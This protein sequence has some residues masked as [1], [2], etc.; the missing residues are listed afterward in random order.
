MNAQEARLI[1][2]TAYKQRNSNWDD[3]F[4]NI[5]AIVTDSNGNFYAVGDG[6]GYV[7]HRTVGSGDVIVAKFLP[8]KSV[9]LSWGNNASLFYANAPGTSFF[10]HGFSSDNSGSF[11]HRTNTVDYAGDSEYVLGAVLGADSN[12]YILERWSKNQNKLAILSVGL[13]GSE[14]G[15]FGSNGWLE[16][17]EY[18]ETYATGSIS[19]AD[20]GS[21]KVTAFGNVYEYPIPRDSVI[22]SAVYLLAPTLSTVNEGSTASF[23]LS[24]S[25]VAAGTALSYVISGVQA[26]DIVGG[27]LTGSVNVGSNGQATISVP[28]AADNLT[29]GTETMT[30]TVRSPQGA[31][32]AST[33]V[34]INDTSRSPVIN[35]SYSLTASAS[36][37]NEGSTASFTLNTSNVAVGTAL[38]YVISGVQ[39]ADIV[40][41]Q[42]TGSVNVGSNGQATISI[43]IAA[44][45]LTEGPETMTVTVRSPQGVNVASANVTIN[46]TSVRPNQSSSGLSSQAMLS[47]QNISFQP[48]QPTVAGI[49]WNFSAADF[50]FRDFG[51]QSITYRF[52]A[53]KDSTYDIYALSINDPLF[54]GIYDERGVLLATNNELFDPLVTRLQ[55]GGEYDSDAIYRWSPDSTGTFY[56][57]VTYSQTAAFPF[58]SF[59]IYEE[60]AVGAVT[61]NPNYLLQSVTSSV[62]EGASAS[63]SL[64]T[65]NL[66]AGT[67]LSYLISGVQA[68][69]IVGGQLSG[70]VTVDA[71]GRATI[72]IPIAA[73]NLTE[74]P[75]T[76]TVTVRSPQGAN[77]ASA[78][79][80]INDT[81]TTRAPETMLRAPAGQSKIA[82]SQP[83]S[84]AVIS[85]DSSG[86][87]TVTLPGGSSNRLEGYKR[88]EFADKTVALDTEAVGGQAYR[89]YKAAFN[90]EPDQGGLGYWIAQ[91]DSGMNMVEVAARFIDSNEF[92]SL[93]GNNP[94]DAVFLTR[95]YQNVLGREPEP[96]GYN[97]WLNELRTNPE[98][99]RA[100]VLADFSES[101]ENKVGVS[102]LISAGVVFQPYTSKEYRVVSR[103]AEVNEGQTA[104]FDVS[105]V[106]VAAGTQLAYTITGVSAADIVGGQLS[107]T[108]NV[109]SN[110]KATISIPIAADNLTEGRETLQV[111]LQ[112]QNA[113]VVINDTS[114]SPVANPTYSLTASTVSVNEGASAVFTLLTTQV[115]AGT[116]FS[117]LL[118]GIQAADIVGGQLSGTVTV[119]AW[120][121]AT[122]SIPIVA[123]NL[124]EGPEVLTVAIR[125][126]QGSTLASSS[127]VIND[128][129]VTIVGISDGGDSGGGG[130]GGGGG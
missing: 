54:L 17:G 56:A 59:E 7:G 49:T 44:D 46:D 10:N 32:V 78:N 117:Y 15:Y 48:Y 75:E 41:G 100:K 13:D 98:K 70:S 125:S 82:F 83:V 22:A 81:S 111:N 89:V 104:V 8:N 40:G 42:L 110:G 61:S 11:N 123:D 119:N 108:I 31:N 51:G 87:W 57:L 45:N 101:A 38:S 72:S 114:R 73:D 3:P 4:W 94:S 69:D 9:D 126:P 43:P 93:Y 71:Q 129:S 18:V 85:Q 109:G 28:I 24:T 47:A 21:I 33:N 128:T 80:T 105:T 122:L 53:D 35:P 102:S 5:A 60:R 84:S 14:N 77:V 19:L 86:S 79:V 120:G 76:M 96:A 65:S 29:E 106:N 95:V 116:S 99:T 16:V 23:T 66:A 6:A 67:A 55:D 74:G 62:N 50:G 27:Q 20:D 2:G 124:T 121:Q 1:L 91:M 64:S 112:G 107:G 130:G 103:A 68:A 90:R 36:S 127:V 12:L 97:W 34:T 58:Y 39:S 63:F 118:S 52:R 92:R 25:N 115:A 37:V 88:V 26:A 30:V 113:S